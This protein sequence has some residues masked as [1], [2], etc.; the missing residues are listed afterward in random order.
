MPNIYEDT[1][2]LEQL[3]SDFKDHVKEN[4]KDIIKLAEAASYL[5]DRTH[6]LAQEVKSL[7][8]QLATTRLY[9]LIMNIALVLIGLKVVFM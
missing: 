9:I 2:H 3:K 8:K 5:S 1:T 4:L 7:K 6:V